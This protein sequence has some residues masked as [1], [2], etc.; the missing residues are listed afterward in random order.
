MQVAYSVVNLFGVRVVK[1][2]SHEFASLACQSIK[3]LESIIK[4]QEHSG[5]Q[6]VSLMI[7]AGIFCGHRSQNHQRFLWA[8]N[9]LPPKVS[10][11]WRAGNVRQTDW[12][13]RQTGRTKGRTDEQMEGLNRRKNWTVWIDG[14]SGWTDKQMD[15]GTNGLHKGTDSTEWT[16]GVER[17]ARRTDV[18]TE[19]MDGQNRRTEM[20][21]TDR[22][23]DG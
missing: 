5:S 23:K 8:E 11:V 18:R 20:D 9:Q 22:G 19:R 17:V 10:F 12:T 1:L 2:E 6:S 16:D 13:D 21:W 14:Q 3:T 7:N 15:G 4:W